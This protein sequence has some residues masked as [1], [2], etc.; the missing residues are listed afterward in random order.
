MKKLLLALLLLPALA[1]TAARAA[2]NTA[3][4]PVPQRGA[5]FTNLHQQFLAEAQKGGIE[6]LFLGD[7]ITDFWRNR[8]KA[9]WDKEYAPLHAANFGISADRTQ[10]VLWRLANG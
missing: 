9:V 2:A 7:S 3:L 4:E 8:G 10:N 5:G 6:V 1:F